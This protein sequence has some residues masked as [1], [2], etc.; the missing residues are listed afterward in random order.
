MSAPVVSGD[1]VIVKVGNEREL[2]RVHCAWDASDGARVA[3][4]DAPG[5]HRFLTRVLV[6][7]SRWKVSILFAN[8]APGRSFNVIASDVDDALNEALE[9][10]WPKGFRVSDADGDGFRQAEVPVHSLDGIDT[11]ILCFTAKFEEVAS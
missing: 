1:K 9:T 7:G 10:M 3:E 4:V 5:M 6:R 8:G 11:A 2:G